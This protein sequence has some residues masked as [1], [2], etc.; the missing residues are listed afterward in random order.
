MVPAAK[1]SIA[2]SAKIQEW[3]EA[4][5]F[6][7]GICELPKL[8]DTLTYY[9]IQ[10]PT[11]IVMHHE[12]PLGIHQVLTPKLLRDENFIL[13]GPDHTT[14]TQLFQAFEQAGV[15]LKSSIQ[16]HLFKNLLP[17][18]KEDMGVALVD[19][20]AIENDHDPRFISRPFT[21]QIYTDM[22]I[23]TSATRPLSQIGSEFLDLLQQKL[24]HYAA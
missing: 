16:S 23:I 8:Y 3:V 9:P 13:M 10:I 22:A 6:E 1:S 14:Q 18:V 17:F 5:I 21:P 11:K 24:K 19:D 20:F 2:I 4:G 7:I 15:K 12:N